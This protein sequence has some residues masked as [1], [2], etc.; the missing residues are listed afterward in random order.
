MFIEFRKTLFKMGK[1]RI[2]A[3]FR[4][5]GLGAIF[6]YLIYLM[7]YMMW[8]SLLASLWLM[9]G[10]LYLLALPIKAIKHQ[11]DI[12]RW[13]KSS[14]LKVTAIVFGCMIVVGIIGNIAGGN[15][16]PKN[17]STNAPAQTE[18]TT[19]TTTEA[20]NEYAEDDTV[21]RFITE[22]NDLSVYTMTDISAGNIRTKYFCK[23]NGCWTEMINATEAGAKAFCITIDGGN[24]SD[25][26]D[27]V[28]AV[29]RDAVK[30]LDPTLTDDEIDNAISDLKDKPETRMLY[31]IGDD[32]RVSYS[33]SVE[34]TQRTTNSKIDISSRNY[35]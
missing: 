3:G 15:F 8:Y 22:Y 10:F 14:V 33:P 26:N 5:K 30:V 17:V 6:V 28:L 20:P 1:F 16:S 13:K 2:K 19:T 32:V 4:V 29:M 25:S 24:K 12:G 31:Q 9:Y 11:V 23:V 18:A 34:L 27:K 7:F 35:K 21:N